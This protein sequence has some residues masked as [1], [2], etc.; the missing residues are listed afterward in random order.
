MKKLFMMLV[1]VMSVLLVSMISNNYVKAETSYLT[2]QSLRLSKGKLLSN[3]TND[4]YKNYYE[5]VDKRKFMG[6][7]TYY[8][9]QNVKC[10]YVSKTVFSYYNRG[11][12][13]ITY[14]YN[15]TD[16]LTEKFSISASGSISYSGQSQGTK[17]FKHGLQTALKL[18]VDYNNTKQTT[19]K[20]NL[21][22]VIDP[23]SVATLKIVGEGKLYNGVAAN[24]VFWIRTRKGGFE[25]FIV[26]TE[27]PRLEVL[28]I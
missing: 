16:S 6:W 2:F 10:S 12:S 21:D 24:Y 28:P 25:Y 18:E 19:T 14:T 5:K 8:A 9:N 22:I 17:T 1:I 4:D 11:T 20:E 23:K 13:K 26:T 7:Q 3:F 15:L 27:Y